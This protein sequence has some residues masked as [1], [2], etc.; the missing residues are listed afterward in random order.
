MVAKKRRGQPAPAPRTPVA[1][2]LEH[3]RDTSGVETLLDFHERITKGGKF[4]VSYSAVRNYHFDRDPP[5]DYLERVADEFGVRLAW[6]TAG[7]GRM[8]ESDEEAVAAVLAV[9]QDREAAAHRGFTAAGMIL[10]WMDPTAEMAVWRAH[11]AAVRLCGDEDDPEEAAGRA[12]ASSIVAAFAGLSLNPWDIPQSA[13]DG[14]VMLV[15]EALVRLSE[16]A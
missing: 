2:R 16:A 12:V 5:L 3:I 8:R 1:R 7:D 4:K 10:D 15:C 6:L 14:A 11:R 9:E 13:R